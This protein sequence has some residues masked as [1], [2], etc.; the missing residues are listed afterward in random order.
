MKNQKRT[1]ILFSSSEIGGAEKTLS[2]LANHGEKNEFYLGS[3]NGQGELLKQTKE[4]RLK[5][6]SFGYKYTNKFNIILSC[7]NAIKFSKKIQADYI[8]ICGFKACTIIRIFS[9]FFNVPKIIH[10]IRWNPISINKDDKIFRIFE[11]LF[12][13][14]TCG[15]I[16][17]SKSTKDTLTI[18]CGIPPN[19]INIIYNGI[20][21]KKPYLRKN[22]NKNVV[23]TLSNFAPRK[24]IIEYLNVIERVIKINSNVK[25][26]I[27]GRDDMNGKVHQEI[28]NKNLEKF[29]ETPGFV[30]QTS[31]LFKISKIMVMPSLLPEGCPTSIL[32]GMSW[33]KPSI[34]YNIEGLKELI[35]NNKTGYLL[36]KYDEK[37]MADC[38]LKLL[39]NP[40]LIE[41]LGYNAY[42][43]I[44]KKFTLNKML[45]KHREFFNYFDIL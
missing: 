14:Q 5:V 10:A 34:G 13:K 43:Q 18:H 7:L 20:D 35:V 44:K 11:R 27:A 33:G 9:I 45:Y 26:I 36:N 22:S 3:L 6:E 1:L 24:G 37:S 4:D 21:V 29:I 30:N 38:I 15:W 28:K 2:R 19:K 40:D 16:C 42:K 17:N 8:Y 39:N 31:D 25:F 23:L 41:K 12:I 32:E